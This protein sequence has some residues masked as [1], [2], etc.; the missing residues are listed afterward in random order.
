MPRP[1]S[2]LQLPGGFCDRRYYSP[3]RPVYFILWG[4]VGFVVCSWFRGVR[5]LVV[6][7]LFV[8]F[9]VFL[10]YLI[11]AGWWVLK[12]GSRKEDGYC[13]SLFSDFH[14]L[15]RCVFF[16]VESGNTAIKKCIYIRRIILGSFN[17]LV[18]VYRCSVLATSWALLCFK[19]YLT[20][21]TRVQNR[22]SS[23]FQLWYLQIS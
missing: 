23:I 8:L 16:H 15:T 5:G 21:I 22:F 19:V 20:R 12:E 13:T 4:F 11:G 6:F 17:H 18:F 3:R 14:A 2:Q 7:V 10:V 1:E 9:V